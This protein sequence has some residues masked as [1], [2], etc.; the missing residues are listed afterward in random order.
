MVNLQVLALD[1]WKRRIMC[2]KEEFVY[3]SFSHIY[4]VHNLV[5]DKLSKKVVGLPFDI[6]YYQIWKNGVLS[7]TVTIPFD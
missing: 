6:L 5:V 7:S 3:I 1:Q 2:L 4:R